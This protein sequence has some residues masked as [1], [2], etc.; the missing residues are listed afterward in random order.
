MLEADGMDVCD[1]AARAVWCST[2]NHGHPQALESTAAHL[3]ASGAFTNEE[4]WLTL[5]VDGVDEVTTLQKLLKTPFESW[6]VRLILATNGALDS[7]RLA[8]LLEQ[9]VS[10]LEPFT[11]WELRQYLSRR[12]VS[13]LWTALPEEAKRLLASPQL[14]K[15]YADQR[16]SEPQEAQAWIPES[17]LA[18]LATCWENLHPMDAECLGR[19]ALLVAGSGQKNRRNPSGRYSILTQAGC[20]ETSLT[21]LLQGD[22]LREG[23]DQRYAFAHER[24]FCHALAR[25]L[26]G[27]GAAEDREDRLVERLRENAANVAP[28]DWCWLRATNGNE[29]DIDETIRV[30]DE[31]LPGPQLGTF[32]MHDLKRLGKRSRFQLD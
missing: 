26:F 21:R 18:L 5:C 23:A 11:N 6:G 27:E 7:P 16:A 30:L 29:A 28:L 14:A 25:G 32:Y 13:S 19:F 10:R 20:S 2:L 22:W 8:S 4:P 9:P 12:G 17:E 31:A 3:K 24:L 1:A 15:L